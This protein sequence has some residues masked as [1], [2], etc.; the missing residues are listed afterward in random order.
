VNRVLALGVFCLL[1]GAL[2]A[3]LLVVG[4]PKSARN[5]KYDQTRLID[6]GQIARTINCETPNKIPS[7]LSNVE[8]QAVCNQR[9][10]K[11]FLSDPKT[12]VRYDFQIIND[13]EVKVCA[14][15]YDVKKLKKS[16][17][18][19]QG[20]LDFKFDGNVGCFFQNLGKLE[21]A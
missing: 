20:T 8:F 7:E 16:R 5:E 1:C 18:Y 6:L 4:S 17:R 21:P 13:V 3:G 2:V 11:G 10:G 15:F 12:E 9:I 19:K 14:T